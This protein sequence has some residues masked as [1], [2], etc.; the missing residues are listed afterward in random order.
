[1]SKTGMIA[2]LHRLSL[3]ASKVTICLSLLMGVK[4]ESDISL[5]ELMMIQSS[6]S[7]DNLPEDLFEAYAALSRVELK[8]GL[9][10]FRNSYW[11]N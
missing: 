8:Q 10:C 2:A 9:R 6:K 11:H 5:W 4:K 7:S 1:M 3:A